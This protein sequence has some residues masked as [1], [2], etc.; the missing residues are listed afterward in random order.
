MSLRV[1]GVVLEEDF[2][3][4]PRYCPELVAL[5]G[6]PW[7]EIILPPGQAKILAFNWGDAPEGWVGGTLQLWPE[8]V[9]VKGKIVATWRVLPLQP[10]PA[11]PR[12]APA[13]IVAPAANTRPK[14][15]APP[16]P[17]PAPAAADELD[18]I[19]DDEIPTFD[20]PPAAAPAAPEKRRPGRPKGGA[21]R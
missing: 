9:T 18:T 21:R 6:Q 15:A 5:D 14:P 4:G 7:G 3:Y 1:C 19:R 2:D 10:P 8:Q 13:P 12:P 20:P 17:P 11:N 16:P